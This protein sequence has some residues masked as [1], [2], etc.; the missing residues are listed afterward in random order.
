LRD[1]KVT[2]AGSLG[3]ARDDRLFVWRRRAATAWLVANEEGLREIAGGRLA[4][5]Q[6]PNR[7]MANLEIAGTDRRGLE[8]I[9][10]RFGGTIAQLP[11]DWLKRGQKAKPVKIGKR[12]VIVQSSAGAITSAS[13]RLLIPA[14]TAFGTGAHATTAM[15]LRLL[16][17]IT[18]RLPKNWSLLD[19]GTGSGIL[20]LAAKRFGA[21]RVLAIDSDPIAISVART[22]ARLNKILGVEFRVGDVRS[23]S[24]AASFDIVSANLYS[25]LLIEILPKLRQNDRLIF[26]G[27]LREEETR[28]LRTLRQNGIEMMNHR[29]RGKWIALLCGC[30]GGGPG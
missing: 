4:I 3:C 11:R 22:N 12:L 26:S 19:L 27:I 17:E 28:F 29:R 7:K 15:S 30:H 20:A 1:L 10:A 18:R 2:S 13:T 16:E 25:E 5:I 8:R 24:T 23:F 14:G 21:R 6:T 9:R